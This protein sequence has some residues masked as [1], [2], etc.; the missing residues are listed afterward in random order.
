MKKTI[1]LITLFLLGQPNFLVAQSSDDDVGFI[2]EKDLNSID[3]FK[4]YVDTLNKYMYR[5]GNVVEKIIG[6]CEKI[7]EAP[8]QLPDST[9]F[10][11]AREKIHYGLNNDDLLL[12]YQIIK[13]HEHML[14]NESIS[15]QSKGYFKYI[16]GYTIMELGDVASAQKI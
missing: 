12:C 3:K 16:K 13:E 4:M 14:N 2:L 15:K 6:E 8:I 7:L 11:Y 1:L 5:D 9:I 10:K